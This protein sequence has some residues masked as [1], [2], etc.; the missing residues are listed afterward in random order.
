ML[1]RKQLS[2]LI[3]LV[4]GLGV[5][6][7]NHDDGLKS[8]LQKNDSESAGLLQE[9]DN[10]PRVF[11]IDKL[12]KLEVVPETSGQEGTVIVLPGVFAIETPS[13]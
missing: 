5:V 9:L 7:C 1:K 3:G 8:G 10:V 6:S 12:E 11:A 13:M 4:L 2:V